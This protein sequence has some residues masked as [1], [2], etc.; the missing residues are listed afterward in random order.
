MTKGRFSIILPHYNQATLINQAIKSVLSQE[1]YDIELII[2]D[3]ASNYFEVNKIKK[4]IELNKKSN[5]KKYEIIVNDINIG[6]VKSINKALSRVTGEYVLFFAADDELNNSKVVNNFVKNFKKNINIITS[7]TLMCDSD[8]SEIEYEYVNS[9]K[10]LTYNDFTAKQQFQMIALSCIYSSGATAYRT[11]IFEK[12]GKFNENYKYVEDWSYWL[13]LTRSGEKIYYRNFVTLNHR[14]GG[15]SH[16]LYTPNNAPKHIR[17][18]YKDILEI[19][20]NEIMT[21]LDKMD[22]KYQLKVMEKF[23]QHIEFYGQYIGEEKQQYQKIY[24]NI[25]NGDSLIGEYYKKNRILLRLKALINVHIIQKIYYE[26]IKNK[27]NK[28]TILLW[29][30]V[31]FIVSY[32]N[33]NVPIVSILLL[34][35]ILNFY[36]NNYLNKKY[37]YFIS[38]IFTI[39]IIYYLSKI[40]VLK[41]PIINLAIIAIIFI[42]I[43]GIFY[44]PY[45]Y[46]RKV[47]RQRKE[48]K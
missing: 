27:I 43:Y 26:V 6:T 25:I 32:V 40:T 1:Y 24:N 36:I 44:I 14:D 28:Y 46:I 10:A 42:A 33:P 11:N 15:I 20:S 30:L 17:L 22:F 3:D 9:N 29:I 4:F 5:L 45:L 7:Q 47:I 12:Y 38:S 39:I 2:I 31:Y 37:V 35:P 18:Y 21:Y 16:N 34:F 23:R 8:L 13:Y 48:K 19:F 41:N